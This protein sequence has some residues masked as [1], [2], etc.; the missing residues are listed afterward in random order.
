MTGTLDYDVVMATR[1]RP[2]AVALSLP[3]LIGQTRAPAQILVVDSSEDPGPISAIVADLADAPVPV[4]YLRSDPGLP[5]QRNVGLA[6]C[7]AEVVMFPDDDS[8]YY[9]D[10][11]ARIMAV[12]E[13]DPR[14]A[15]VAGRPADTPPEGAGLTGAALASVDA[16]TRGGFTRWIGRQRLKMQQRFDDLDPVLAVGRRLNESHGRLQLPPGLDAVAVPYMT[17]FR[18]TYR[19]AAIA[20]AGFDEV[21]KAYAPAEDI[22]GSFTALRSGPVVAA[23]QAMI[24]HHRVAGARAGGERLGLWGVL[25]RSYVVLK[26]VDANP[27][28]FGAAARAGIAGDLRRFMRGRV[29]G[30][31]LRARGGFGRDRLRGARAGL[32]RLPDLIAAEGPDLPARYAALAQD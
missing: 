8:L 13:A 32:A 15:G 3:L 30:Y 31:A 24:Y 29:T 20:A 4:R 10:T 11:A 16:E 1:N 2:E 22:D 6:E 27:G 26:H 7:R 21:L 19:R 5:H 28:L 14:I 12:Y 23:R 18:M 17:G 25:N 9:P